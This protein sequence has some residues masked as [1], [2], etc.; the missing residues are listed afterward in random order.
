MDHVRGDH[1][2]YALGKRCNPWSSSKASTFEPTTNPYATRPNNINPL[3][4]QC[5][6]RVEDTY[7][8]DM[9]MYEAID[10]E[11]G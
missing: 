10:D 9:D 8:S 2:R 7:P 1:S 3:Q 4:P 6:N 5:A 11:D